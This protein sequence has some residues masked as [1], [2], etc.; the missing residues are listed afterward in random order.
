[1]YSHQTIFQSFQFIY[2]FIIK[3]ILFTILKTVNLL[4]KFLAWHIIEDVKGRWGDED[5]ADDNRLYR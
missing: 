3:I 2:W 5:F 1:M 4:R